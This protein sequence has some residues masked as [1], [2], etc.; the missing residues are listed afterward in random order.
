[1]KFYLRLFV[2][3]FVV[4]TLLIGTGIFIYL[5]KAEAESLVEVED[6]LQL[7]EVT[8]P[9]KSPD[10]PMTELDLAIEKSKR[11][12][13]LLMGTDGG[14]ADTIMLFSF[15]PERRLMDIVSIPRDTYND[16]PG[17][18]ASGQKKI[19]AVLGFGDNNGGPEGMTVQVSKILRVPI[20]YYFMVDYDAVKDVVDT[21]GG[22]EIDVPFNMNYDDD[23]ADP[24][25]HI[26]LNKGL[27]VLDGDKAIQFIRW[28]KNNG[29]EGK[30]DL[31]RID[32][33]QAFIKEAI[34]KSMSLKLPSV[35]RTAMQY[36]KTNMPLEQAL[37]Y[38]GEAVGLKVEDM[39]N[40]QIPG[41]AKMRGLSYYIHDPALTEA[42]M[43]EI[44]NRRTAEELLELSTQDET[45]TTTAP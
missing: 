17:Y 28:R 3:S 4:F 14:R 32:R 12:N 33:Q 34:K 20:H 22:V 23:M 37:Y 2:L 41:E 44:Y 9:D 27:Q 30:G 24:P 35:V 11:L 40:A 29:S 25:L 38:A 19:N 18:D 1:M 21:I 5:Q 42:M 13:V 8:V 36:V 39:T 16:V 43:L 10:Q 26:H 15:D 45:Q 7:P 6:P 31:S